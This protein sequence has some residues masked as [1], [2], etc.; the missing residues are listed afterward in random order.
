MP[1]M[2]KSKNDIPWGAYDSLRSARI[3][4]SGVGMGAYDSQP[5]TRV[6]KKATPK[7]SAIDFGPR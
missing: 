3:K 7:K 1:G 6:K 2:K 5:A 4:R